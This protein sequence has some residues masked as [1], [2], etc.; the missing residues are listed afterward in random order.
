M[1]C[2]LMTIWFIKNYREKGICDFTE[3][4]VISRAWNSMDWKEFFDHPKVQIDLFDWIQLIAQR[5]TSTPDYQHNVTKHCKY[6]DLERRHAERNFKS[7]F[8]ASFIY[9]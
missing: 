9:I 2:D 8:H 7:R 4:N 6:T 1:V 3:I 5:K